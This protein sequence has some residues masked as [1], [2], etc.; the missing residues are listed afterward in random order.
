MVADRRRAGTHSVSSPGRHGP[1][2]PLAR[3]LG[4]SR[5]W[6]CRNCH[7]SCASAIRFFRRVQI[8]L[9]TRPCFAA[10]QF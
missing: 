8:C 4:L 3:R 2:R 1:H 5:P 7:V 6:N 10:N 9:P